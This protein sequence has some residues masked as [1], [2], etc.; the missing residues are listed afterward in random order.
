MQGNCLRAVPLVSA[1]SLTG[2]HHQG[3]HIVRNFARTRFAARDNVIFSALRANLRVAVMD[4]VV[5][6]EISSCGSYSRAKS[7]V[8]TAISAGIVVGDCLRKQTD[9]VGDCSCK[10]MRLLAMD[11]RTPNRPL[12]T[13]QNIG[14]SAISR[15]LSIV[16]SSLSG[17]SGGR[18]STN[19]GLGRRLRTSLRLVA[20][21]PA[22]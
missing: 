15:F 12:G 6:Y 11:A 17:R 8:K 14:H 22:M 2:L 5:Y 19:S 7:S 9:S 20:T 18:G 21:C 13:M 1:D 4:K 10:T 16:H 3:A